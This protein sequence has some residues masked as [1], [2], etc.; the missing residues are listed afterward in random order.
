MV[1]DL[2]L[3]GREDHFCRAPG[4]RLGRGRRGRLLLG[5]PDGLDQE[6]GDRLLVESGGLVPP[7][8]DGREPGTR[9]LGLAPDQEACR[10]DAALLIDKNCV[11]QWMG[12]YQWLP[13][14]L[15]VNLVDEHR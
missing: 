15:R 1:R 7:L 13:V 3:L 4:Q 8:P 2:D 6:K 5:G 12:R 11:E 14:G 9:L 10:T